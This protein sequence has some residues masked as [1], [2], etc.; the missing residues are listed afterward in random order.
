MFVVFIHAWWLPK[1]KGINGLTG[2]PKE[3][4]Y[5]FRGWTKNKS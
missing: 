2:E 4:Y 5:E 3:K 1:K